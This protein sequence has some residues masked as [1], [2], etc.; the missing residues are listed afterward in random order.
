MSFKKNRVTDKTHDQLM[1]ANWEE[2][3]L[4][5]K[6]L[7]SDLERHPD[8]TWERALELSEMLPL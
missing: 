2:L 6:A 1:A 4:M 8:M 7:R 5:E 3:N